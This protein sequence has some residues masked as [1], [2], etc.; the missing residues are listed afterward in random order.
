MNT[1]FPVIDSSGMQEELLTKQQVWTFHTK[2]QVWAVHTHVEVV[3][4]LVGY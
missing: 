3:H 1:Y 4:H 2:Q